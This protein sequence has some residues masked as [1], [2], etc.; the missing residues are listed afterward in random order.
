MLQPPLDG[1]DIKIAKTVNVRTS[2]NI[3]GN[4]VANGWFVKSL[5]CRSPELAAPKY[6][7]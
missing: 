5:R 7:R 3:L 6:V 1:S 4:G 2:C